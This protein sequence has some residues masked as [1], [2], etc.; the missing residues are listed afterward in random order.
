M[1]YLSARHAGTCT[2]F[3]TGRGAGAS[4]KRAPAP[5]RYA[6][7]ADKDLSI[8]PATGKRDPGPNRGTQ[9]RGGRLGDE[10]TSQTQAIQSIANSI[11]GYTWVRRGT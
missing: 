4:L 5:K 10:V 7:M 6:N 11:Q 3:R 2:L 9:V 8:H 1:I